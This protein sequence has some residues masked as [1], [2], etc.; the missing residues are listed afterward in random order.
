MEGLPYFTSELRVAIG[1][2]T[3]APSPGVP[4]S[5]SPARCEAKVRQGEC[6]RFVLCSQSVL[7]AA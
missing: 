2:L 5:L 4:F 6:T 3:L 7:L 1:G